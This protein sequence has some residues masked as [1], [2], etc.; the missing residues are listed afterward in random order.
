MR[1]AAIASILRPKELFH[2]TAAAFA[3]AIAAEGLRAGPEGCVWATTSLDMAYDYAVWATALADPESQAAGAV[4]FAVDFAGLQLGEERHSLSPPPPWYTTVC[5]D[6]RVFLMEDGVAPQ[7]LTVHSSYEVPELAWPGMRERVELEAEAIGA[8]WGGL[9][10]RQAGVMRGEAPGPMSAFAKCIPAPGDGLLRNAME[11]SDR[12]H[13][14]WHGMHHWRGVAAAGLQIIQ[15]GCPADPAVVYAFAVLH[16]AQRESEGHDPDHG[17]RAARL[18]D[19]LPS[20]LRFGREQWRLLREALTD[21]DRGLTHRHPTI[22]ACWDADRLTLPR[23]GIKVD[24]ALLSTQQARDLRLADCV[25]DQDACD[26]EW[27][28]FRYQYAD[29]FSR[30]ADERCWWGDHRD[31][32]VTNVA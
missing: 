16:D 11:A 27:V 13:S 17:A 32:K 1:D 29:E 15:A 24:P 18:A 4:I 22:G 26:W 28:G 14:K 10:G 5:C 8:N 21:H 7:R 12:P 25:I 3:D 31:A 2:G 6:G 23:L 9:L 30:R 20:E 19:S